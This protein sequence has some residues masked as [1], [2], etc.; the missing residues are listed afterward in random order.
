MDNLRRTCFGISTPIIRRGEGAI[1]GRRVDDPTAILDQV[2]AD[3]RIALVNLLH[4][5]RRD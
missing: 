2:A 1:L 5:P 4:E 3:A